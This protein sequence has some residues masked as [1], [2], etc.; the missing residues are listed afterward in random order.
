MARFISY[1]WWILHPP[2]SPSS[3]THH[4]RFV[5]TNLWSPRRSLAHTNDT[6]LVISLFVFF[7][8]YQKTAKVPIQSSII[9]QFLLL[10]V[11]C[12][13]ETRISGSRRLPS[14]PACARSS[15]LHVPPR[16][17]SWVGGCSPRACSDSS[18]RRSS[19]PLC[20]TSK[21]WH[22]ARPSRKWAVSCTRSIHTWRKRR[23]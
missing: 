8:S 3:Q 12:T 2:P 1:T 9:N 11:V 23:R 4:T 7:F 17:R 18:S 19:L 21:T 16:G 13:P 10:P 22:A 14:W 5:H 20:A 15:T 6:L